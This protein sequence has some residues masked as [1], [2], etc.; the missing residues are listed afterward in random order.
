MVVCPLDRKPVSMIIKNYTIRQEVDSQL[1]TN[2]EQNAHDAQIDRYNN[3]FSRADINFGAR[4][5]WLL[6]MLHR[7]NVLNHVI[8]YVVMI[9][10][11]LYIFF[12]WDLIPEHLF[13][14][15]GFLDDLVVLLVGLWFLFFRDIPGYT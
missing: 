10:V 1:A 6:D 11:V 2:N 8:M 3:M 9:L 12:P 13:G 7:H 14:P 15:L 4:D 5:T